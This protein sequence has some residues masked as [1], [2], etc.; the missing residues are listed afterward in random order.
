MVCPFG[1][2]GLKVWQ[3]FI[4]PD[5]LEL[6]FRISIIGIIC[7]A[8]KRALRFCIS[9]PCNLRILVIYGIVYKNAVYLCK[10]IYGFIAGT[11]FCKKHRDILFAHKSILFHILR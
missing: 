8:G 1:L 4:L 10:E 7:D 5:F 9:R 11:D 3:E 6:C 2:P